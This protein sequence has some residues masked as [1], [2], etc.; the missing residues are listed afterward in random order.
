MSRRAKFLDREPDE[1]EAALRHPFQLQV[2]GWIRDLIAQLRD[3]GSLLKSP[4]DYYEYQRLIF[5]YLLVAEQYQA[6][7]S[8]NVKRARAGKPVPA[9]QSGSWELEL[10]VGDRVVRQLRS[11]GDALAWRCFGFDRRFIL[12]LSANERAGPM[13][14][15]AGLERELGEVVEIWR[16]ER[17]FALLH[18]LTSVLRIADVTK[19]TKQRPELVEVKAGKKGIPAAQMSRI[20]RAMDVINEGAPLPGQNGDSSLFVSSIQFKTHLKAL[21]HALALAD[22]QGVASVGVSR[23]WVVTCMSLTSPALPYSFDEAIGTWNRKRSRAFSKAGLAV[24][25]QHHLRGVYGDLWSGCLCPANMR[26]P[27]L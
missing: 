6:T 3:L 13:V 5:S 21:A 24:P 18:D 20:Q 22:E 25:G 4:G 16:R 23:K 2:Y 12:A 7:A 15:K 9:T 17:S 26:F 11:V 8:R 14:G 1:I 10:Y 27:R 19:F